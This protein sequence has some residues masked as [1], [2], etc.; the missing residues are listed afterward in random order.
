ME[1]FLKPDI[2]SMIERDPQEIFHEIFTRPHVQY[3]VSSMIRGKINASQVIKEGDVFFHMHKKLKI[4]PPL[5]IVN[6]KHS[7]TRWC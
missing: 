4:L 5:T 2:T 7:W 1:K 6:L 3:L